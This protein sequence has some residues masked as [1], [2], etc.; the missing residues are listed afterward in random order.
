MIALIKKRISTLNHPKEILFSIFFFIAYCLGFVFIEHRDTTYH[1][2]SLPIDKQIPFCAPFV[3]AYYSWFIYSF[4]LLFLFFMVSEEDYIKGYRFMAIGMTIF[5]LFNI[6]YP[7][8]LDIRPETVPGN[9]PFAALIRTMYAVDTP[10]NV[11]PS[12]HVYNSIAMH[13][14]IINSKWLRNKL[15]TLSK[16]NE[17]LASSRLRILYKVSTIWALLIILSTLF[18]KQHSIVDIIGGLVLA[19]IVYLFVYGRIHRE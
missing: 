19:G 8:S 11:F 7:T 16:G 5:I 15:L 2:V 4:L 12:I 1:L 3:L 9:G 17:I 18:I 6:V 13:A 10:T 14:I